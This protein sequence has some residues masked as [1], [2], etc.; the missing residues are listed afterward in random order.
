M[1]RIYALL[2]LLPL[3]AA[4][5]PFSKNYLMS[6]HTCDAQCMGFQDHEVQLAE[7]NDGMSWTL[8]PNFPVY[9]GSV[10]DVIVRG[11]KVYIYTPGSVRR[12]DNGTGA[13]ES[14]AQPV[15]VVDANSNP[16]NYVDPSAI[17]DS[18]GNIVLFFL[19]STGLTGDPAGCANYPCTKYFN[20]ATEIPGSDGTQF[21]MN[22]GDRITVT[23]NS[24]PQTASDPDIY[25]NGADYILY[26]SKGSS[27][28]AAS[29]P[30]LHGSY[31]LFPNLPNGELVQNL[32]GI[33][34][35]HYKAGSGMYWTYVHSNV[36]GSTEIR[37]AAHSDFNA[38]LANLTTVMS[39]PIIGQP[40]T[41]KTES[42]GFCVN[43]LVTGMEETA[44][45]PL[46][47]SVSP[48][49]VSELMSIRLDQNLRAGRL[50]LFD[51]SGKCV[52][53][54][55]F[56]GNVIEAN[57]ATLGR[58]IYMAEVQGEKQIARLKIMRE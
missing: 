24:S 52:L 30:S 9:Q 41:T 2:L 5:Q 10:P 15:S 31:T 27:T 8:V 37:M 54:K 4:A 11:S 51:L 20:S 3:S 19:N 57:C 53:E 36:S 17:I 6:F 12:F 26:I 42:P 35:G 14:S 38:P 46:G 32:G 45:I 50:R 39:G 40:S 49:P 22:S 33:P 25:F 55:T 21:T 44:A 56:S 28:L 58:G 23:L 48:N 47:A 18:A 1:L 13:W 29:C 16:V 7:S 43:F 34:C